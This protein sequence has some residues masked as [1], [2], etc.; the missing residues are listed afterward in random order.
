MRIKFAAKYS[1]IENKNNP[2]YLKTK[3]TVDK[4][5]RK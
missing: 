3:I 5:L 2:S 1:A 4:Y